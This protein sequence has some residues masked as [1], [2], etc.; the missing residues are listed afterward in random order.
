MVVKKPA[1]TVVDTKPQR[2][3]KTLAIPNN[4]PI[5]LA[6]QTNST[7]ENLCFNKERVNAN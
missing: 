1:T 4:N 6:K 5:P 3:V 2:Q 7:P